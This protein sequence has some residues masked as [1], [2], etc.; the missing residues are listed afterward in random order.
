MSNYINGTRCNYKY[1]VILVSRVKELTNAS[2]KF[3]VET[4]AKQLFMTGLVVLFRDC[5]VVVVEGGV[6][7]QAKYKRYVISIT[8]LSSNLFCQ[9][10]CFVCSTCSLQRTY[11]THSMTDQVISEEFTQFHNCECV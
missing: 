2:K 7:Q 10:S 8:I 11:A 6:K 1:H 5:N 4:N 9:S 3:K